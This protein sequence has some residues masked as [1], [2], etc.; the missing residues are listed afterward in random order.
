M[1][2]YMLSY[3]SKIDLKHESTPTFYGGFLVNYTPIEKLNLFANLYYYSRQVFR[4]DDAST[5]HVE[6]V[7]IDAKTIIDFK[8]SFKVY[9]E[10]TVFVNAR[11]LLGTDSREFAFGDETSGMYLVG[12]NLNF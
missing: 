2:G 7:N 1:Y 4:Y 8:A 10:N 5:G 3:P 9:K 11:N 6:E 12:L